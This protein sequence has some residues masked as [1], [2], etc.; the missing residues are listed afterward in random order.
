M[1]ATTTLPLNRIQN[2]AG[3]RR[4]SGRRAGILRK[5]SPKRNVNGKVIHGVDL[6]DHFRF[7]PENDRQRAL[8]RDENGNVKHL[9]SSDAFTTLYGKKPNYI[10]CFI[11]GFD[12]LAHMDAQSAEFDRELKR[13]A[14]ATVYAGNNR[15]AET[16]AYGVWL[17][18]ENV[19]GRWR[20]YELGEKP[21]PIIPND[22]QDRLYNPKY[23]IGEEMYLYKDRLLPYRFSGNIE[24]YLPKL[25]SM[26]IWGYVEF[27]TSSK[28]EIIHLTEEL[29]AFCASGMP[30][31][32]F[33]MVIFRQEQ[34]ITAPNFDRSKNMAWRR[35]NRAKIK[36]WLVHFE[37]TPELAQALSLGRVA[38]AEAQL[39]AMIVGQLYGTTAAPASPQLAEL[40][41]PVRPNREPDSVI[42]DSDTGEET[43]IYKPTS[44]DWADF[45]TTADQPE[46]SVAPAPVRKPSLNVDSLHPD[47][48]VIDIGALTVNEKRVYD[49][50]SK[51]WPVALGLD[52]SFPKRH[53][54]AL[55]RGCGVSAT[56]NPY[57]PAGRVLWIRCI[58]DV[59]CLHKK[60]VAPAELSNV[61]RERYH[62]EKNCIGRRGNKKPRIIPEKG[63]A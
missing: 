60:G 19:N 25:N 5:G 10:E 58:A 3:R 55:L 43:P 40:A 7:V 1:L 44:D 21:V 51:T 62:V 47:P 42:V 32:Y 16:D 24:L 30:L 34:E 29:R 37:P 15:I 12:H 61:I 39:K 63:G 23:G 14:S 18:G 46:E 48:W 53:I 4:A 20:T 59:L 6:N 38:N 26:G 54:I 17:T 11:G 8:H 22:P 33:P 56:I 52:G 35:S 57:D 50:T 36:K 45:A 27:T 9:S 49:D 41:A 2:L 31:S 13:W 28:Y